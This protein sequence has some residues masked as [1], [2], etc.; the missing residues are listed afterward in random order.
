[1]L[2]LSRLFT[3]G[4]RKCVAQF[5]PQSTFPPSPEDVVHGLPLWEINW[6][7]PPTTG[8]LHVTPDLVNVDFEFVE[9]YN[10]INDVADLSAVRVTGG[11]RFDYATSGISTLQP[12]TY[13][14]IVGNQQVFDVRYGGNHTVAG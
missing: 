6:Q 3:N 8:A 5:L 7:H 11:I 14:W 13:V 4:L 12:R 2:T 1:M 9:L 10:P